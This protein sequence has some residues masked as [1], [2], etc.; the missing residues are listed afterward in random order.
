[1]AGVREAADMAIW[2]F[3]MESSPAA[4]LA[5]DQAADGHLGIHEVNGKERGLWR[6]TIGSSEWTLKPSRDDEFTLD[7][8]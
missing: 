4:R 3:M 1:M 7:V 2:G 6:R 8:Q 5:A